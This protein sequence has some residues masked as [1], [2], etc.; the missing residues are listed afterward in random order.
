MKK[1]LVIRGISAYDVLGRAADEICEGVRKCG[2]QVDMIGATDPGAD[3]RFIECL[4]HR[5][6]Y[7]FYF[8]IQ[9]IL[10]NLESENLP[11]LAEMKRVG[12]IVDDP[13]YHQ[14]RIWGSLGTNARLLM[15]RDSHAAQLREEFSKFERVETLY[16]GGF[17]PEGWVPY[18]KKDITL[19]FPGTYK[20]LRDSESRIDAIPGVF[21][22]IAKQV[23]P[24]IVGEHLA[25]SW[26]E[27]VR[28]YLREIGFEYSEDE[29]FAMQKVLEPLD[30]YQRDYMRQSIIETLLTNGLKVAVVGA[31]WDAY[32]GAGRENLEILSSE[33]VDITEVIKLMQRSRIV[34]NNTN[35]LDGMHERI[36]TAMLAGAV[37][38]TN[39]YTLLSKLLVPEKEIVTFPLNRLEELPLQ[40]KDLLEHEERA[41][42][43]A[44]AG[45]QKALA[46]HTWQ[47]RGE[48]IVKWMEDGG[49]FQYE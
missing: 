2:Y 10:W 13:V 49:D 28:N 19:F 20:P 38:V 11:E 39:E 16:H 4:E 6:Q 31:G 48:Q 34:I 17:L 32:D 29:F 37:C 8:S 3:D 21:G 14:K 15:V 30:Q 33:G 5:D 7:A 46:H 18:H 1:I 41:A 47:H 35:I 27:E 26:T 36:F 22:T 40:I 25:S 23:M 12:W 42:E 9:A 24:R 44:E 45:Y 43:I